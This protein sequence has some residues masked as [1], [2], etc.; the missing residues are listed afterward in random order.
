MKSLAM[1]LSPS[2]TKHIEICLEG[3]SNF[4]L[5]FLR[6]AVSFAK[7]HPA[8]GTSE[9]ENINASGAVDM[10]VG[11]FMIFCENHDAERSESED[12]GHFAILSKEMLIEAFGRGHDFGL[13]RCGMRYAGT[14][15]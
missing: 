1:N 8:F 15:L 10:H 12:G 11:R 2:C 6:A 5:L 13:L 7:P 3:A 4:S 9:K 14:L